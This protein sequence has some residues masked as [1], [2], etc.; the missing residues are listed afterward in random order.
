[1]KINIAY[2]PDDK[3]VNQTIVSMVS[4]LQNNKSHEIE[5]IIMYSSLTDE[6]VKKLNAIGANVRFLKMDESMFSSLPLSNWVTI[7]A[8]FRIKL[9]D[10]CEDLDK[11]LYLDCDTL[12]LGDLGELF[13]TN[14]EGKFLAGVK[15]IWGVNRYVER[16][17]MQS[18]I[19]LNSGMLLFNC[20]YCRREK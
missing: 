8:W 9:P 1:M 17:G 6:S 7:Q 19:Y 2:A 11:I 12:V 15:D 10:M 14:L 16:L 13:N 3:Y 20:D 18:P 5:F 4:A